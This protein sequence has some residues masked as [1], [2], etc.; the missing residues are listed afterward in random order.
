MWACLAGAWSNSASA[1]GQRFSDV[2]VDHEA[3]GAVEWAAE[4]G[5]TTGYSDGTFRPQEPLRK[6]HAVVFMQRYYDQILKAERSP[7]FTR[8]DMMMLLHTVNSGKPRNQ[9]TFKAVT[10]GGWHSCGLRTDGTVAYWGFL[11]KRTAAG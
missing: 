1:Q 9:D 3:H 6:K 5:V 4:V 7:E 11:R 2:P 10:A 8:A